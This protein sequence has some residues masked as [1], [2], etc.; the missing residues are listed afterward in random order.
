MLFTL[1]AA[2]AIAAAPVCDAVWHDAA[3]DRDVPVKL[4]MPTGSDRVPLVV[5]SPG[6]GGDVNGGTGWGQAWA[7]AGMIVIHVQHP[8]SDSAV[9][10]G[11]AKGEDI[12]A[13]V[14]AAAS[15]EQ[16]LARVADV[17][18]V[19]NEA[20]RRPVE[21][22]C[23]LTRI[24]PDHIGM[25]GHSMGA[26]TTQALAG[27]RWAGGETLADRRVRAAI[28]FSPSAPFVGSAADAFGK[29]GMPFLTITGTQ[30]GTPVLAKMGVRPTAPPDRIIPYRAM[31]PG[32]KYLIV[33]DGADHMVFSGNSRRVDRGS[34]VHVKSVTAAA[35]TAF[36]QATLMG[37]AKAAAWLRAPT[38]LRGLL[39]AG[40]VLETK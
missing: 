1:I 27:Q 33:F 14:R 15:A 7:A 3:R 10:L 17:R 24:D 40:D 28:A 26:W 29:I 20:M 30:D 13:R 5:F 19:L 35:T 12:A 38:G 34:D 6:L 39:A 4:R 11:A 18:F 25:A 36:W 32:D 9:Y 16:L 8:G 22:A 23:D 21:G 31:P 2:A 37:D